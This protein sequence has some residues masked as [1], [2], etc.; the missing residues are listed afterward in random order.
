MCVLSGQPNL[1]TITKP[2]NEPETIRETNCLCLTYNMP[3]RKKQQTLKHKR[4][5]TPNSYQFFRNLQMQEDETLN[6]KES[7]GL[8]C[9]DHIGTI[10]LNLKTEL[11][12]LFFPVIARFEGQ[13]PSNEPGHRDATSDGKRKLSC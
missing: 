7:M 12:E 8:S 5:K 3:S 11:K 4:K 1:K 9:A 13:A 2:T 6:L 10:I